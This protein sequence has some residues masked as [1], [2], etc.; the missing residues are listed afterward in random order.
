M[1]WTMVAIGGGDD[2]GRVV[3]LEYSRGRVVL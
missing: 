3:V 2:D 1:L